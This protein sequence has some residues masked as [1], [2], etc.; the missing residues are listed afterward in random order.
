M[1]LGLGEKEQFLLKMRHIDSQSA[2]Y[3]HFPNL[4]VEFLSL[5]KKEM[6]PLKMAPCFFPCIFIFLV[7]GISKAWQ[8]TLR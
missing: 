5:L 6:I 7:S 4:P 8:S 3:I 1:T 2:P